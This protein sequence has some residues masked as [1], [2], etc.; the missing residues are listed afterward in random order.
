M[1]RL[2]FDAHRNELLRLQAAAQTSG[3]NNAVEV[4]AV[5]EE[6]N[7]YELKY[8]QLKDD[9]QVRFIRKVLFS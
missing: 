1:N 2:E 9:V 6:A 5:Q 3:A 7:E 8:N 4:H